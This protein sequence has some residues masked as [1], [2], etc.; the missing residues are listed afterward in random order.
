MAL[1]STSPTVPHPDLQEAVDFH[2]H[3]TTVDMV[4]DEIVEPVPVP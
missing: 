1:V 4:I 2:D 3:G